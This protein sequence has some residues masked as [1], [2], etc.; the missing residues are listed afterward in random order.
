M[1]NCELWTANNSEGLVIGGGERVIVGFMKRLFDMFFSGIGLILLSPIMICVGLSI[2]RDGGPAFFRQ[3]RVGHNGTLF[4]IY[5]FRTMVPG[6]EKMGAQITAGK[7]PRIT[8]IGDIIRRKKVDELPQLINVFCGQMSLVGPRPEV[9]KYVAMWGEENRKAI[10]S[11]RPGITDY[12]SLI[13]SNEQ[14]V[15]SHMKDPET[16]YVMEIL[17]RKVALYR[18]YVRETAVWLDFRVILATLAKVAG[19]EGKR[20]L[21]ELTVPAGQLGGLSGCL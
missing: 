1:V 5:K 6:A 9:S 16:G 15:L 17:P 19:V 8:K 12:A 11:V 20:L 2:R 4:R 3:E 21:P 7:D 14:E 10:L 18:K 13:F